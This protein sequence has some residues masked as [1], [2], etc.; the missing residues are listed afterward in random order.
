[1]NFGEAIKSCFNN[2]ANF[3]GRA[4]R[5]EYWY[6]ALFEVLIGLVLEV[7]TIATKSPVFVLIFALF[8]LATVLP[9]LAVTV[10]RL[11][12]TG[13]S[14]WWYFIGFVP[15]IGGITLLIFTLLPS[16][17]GANQF[18]H[19]TPDAVAAG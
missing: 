10:R 16:T 18:D 7:L 14:G 6:W 8:A 1:V 19:R 9:T 12:D 13:R 4:R 11:H 3:R 2:Y 17:P 15:L 5:S